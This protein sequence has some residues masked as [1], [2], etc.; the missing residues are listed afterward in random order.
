[1]SD[2]TLKA[3]SRSDIG[4]GASRRLRRLA[5]K[6]PAIVYGGKE[7]AKSI[8]LEH[9]E[10][11]NMLDDEAAYS[12]IINLVIDGETEEVLIK[13]LQRHP[14]KLKLL[15]VDFKRI[16]RGENMEANV[17]LHFINEDKAPGKKD[18]GVMS[19]QLTTVEISCRPRN[20]P[21]YIEVD[22]GEMNIGDSIH[23]SEITLPE[24][25]EL[26]AFMHGDV[27]ENDLTVANMVP[28]A[29]E[30]VEDDADEVDETEV[31]ASE[32][33][34]DEGDDAEEKNED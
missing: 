32:Q 4:K 12:S 10:I 15:H 22:L 3:E 20:L 13:D 25:V 6:I 14:Y 7:D 2:F 24:G 9:D 1:M 8:T 16:V 19:H 28:P 29:V 27:E 23:L 30:E 33:K 18:G 21:E 5:D 17:P 31:P 11:N 26:V 34:G